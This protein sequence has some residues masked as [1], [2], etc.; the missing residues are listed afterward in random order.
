MK[1]WPLLLEVEGR[2]IRT[3]KQRTLAF[4]AQPMRICTEC[5]QSVFVT[6][7]QTGSLKV[8]TTIERYRAVLKTFGTSIQGAVS[9]HLKNQKVPKLSLNEAVQNLETLDN[10]LKETVGN[11]MEI[12]DKPCKPSGMVGTVSSQTS[13]S[14]KMILDSLKALKQPLQ[15]LNPTYE[16]D[17]HAC[18]TVQV[19]N[20]H[21]VCHFKK[22]L[23]TLLQYAWNFSNTSYEGTKRVVQWAHTPSDMKSLIVSQT[24]AL[25]ALPRMSHPNPARKRMKEGGKSC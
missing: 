11:L 13:S 9:V 8:I 5:N 25:D 4:P 23:P 1:K 3:E 16:I 20:V 18:L 2:E 10:F 19:E 7:A 12:F 17:L 14:A 21:A 22:Q 6:D 15:E 24:T